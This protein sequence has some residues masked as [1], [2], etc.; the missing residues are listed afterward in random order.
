MIHF[1][2]YFSDGLVQPPTNNDML[3]SLYVFFAFQGVLNPVC[4]MVTILGIARNRYKTDSGILMSYYPSQK[5]NERTCYP[6]PPIFEFWKLHLRN[7]LW[8][9]LYIR[10]YIYIVF[11]MY[12]VYLYLDLL[13]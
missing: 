1:D 7:Y 5:K 4:H 13:S 6:W 2:S 3:S 9:H 10:I 11:L 8:T 12:T